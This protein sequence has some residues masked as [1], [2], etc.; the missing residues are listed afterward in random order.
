M[1]SFEHIVSRIFAFQGYWVRPSAKVN[2][3]TE[4]RMKIAESAFERDKNENPQVHASLESH[5]KAARSLPRPE[6]DLLAY[7]P[8][9]KIILAIECKSY[10]NSIGVQAVGFQDKNHPD[11]SRYKIFTRP[12]YREVVLERLRLDLLDDRSANSEDT[13]KLCLAY[14]KVK[15]EEDRDYIYQ[16]F[17]SNGWGVFDERYLREKLVKMA[18]SDYSNEILDIATKILF[19]PLR[20]NGMGTQPH[21]ASALDHLSDI[22]PRLTER[23]RDGPVIPS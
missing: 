5:R 15:S 6:I 23:T 19:G 11:A 22:F 17:N 13:I 21:R 12:I 4:D 3:T 7:K 10:I 18:D 2:L 14:G 1:D 9:E 8:Q 20:K 16:C